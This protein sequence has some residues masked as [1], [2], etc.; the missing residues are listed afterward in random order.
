MAACTAVLDAIAPR[1][2]RST[3]TQART[4]AD[5]SVVPTTH[6]LLRVQIT[7]IMQYENPAVQD[8]IRALKYDDSGAA[9]ALAAAA[10][11]DYLREEIASLKQFS[12]REILL[13]PVPLHTARSRERGFN[14]IERVLRALPQEFK[15]GTLARLSP[16]VFV[17]TRATSPQTR[18]PRAE[19]LA[20]VAGAFAVPDHIRA[21]DA[22][23][24]LI[25]DVATT[26]ATLKHAG[27]PLE[28]AGAEVFRIALARA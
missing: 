28:K 13:V 19:R 26:G 25:D 27:I 6:E 15:D 16:E 12:P 17:R 20:N 18:L 3:R 8:L 9:A 23:I 24:F 14:Q 22:R 5:I 7:T 1:R 21:R 11:A 2:A 4:L 10:L